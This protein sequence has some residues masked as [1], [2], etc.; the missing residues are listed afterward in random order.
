MAAAALAVARAADAGNSVARAADAGNSV[1]R[2][3][4]A[5]NS[6]ARAAGAVA[7]NGEM[8]PMQALL[9]LPPRRLSL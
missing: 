1:A 8:V 7:A 4:D 3:A 6:V 5:G 2:A 9:A